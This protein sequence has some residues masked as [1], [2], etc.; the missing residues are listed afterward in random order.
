M[1]LADWRAR[2]DIKAVVTTRLDGNLA[3]HVG[4]PALARRNRARLAKTLSLPQ[5]P[6]WMTQVHG[7]NVYVAPGDGAREPEADAAFS[8]E[9]DLPLVVLVADCLPIFLASDNGE[10]A[11]VHAGW[12]G[13]AANIIK[14]AVAR[15]GTGNIIAWMGPAIGPC[16]Y[17]VDAQVRD[18]FG[19]NNGFTRGRDPE[20]W[21]MDLQSIA[22]DQLRKA[23]V[24]DI[25]GVGFCTHCD[26]RFYSHRENKAQGRMAAVIWRQKSL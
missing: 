23:G 10:I 17:E 16:H 19:G 4:D 18:S 3:T 14:K 15:F 1:I 25:S 6:V 13:L 22:S 7:T 9:S 20:H 8:A 11:V 21:F 2:P 24:R 12:R 26:A 5:A